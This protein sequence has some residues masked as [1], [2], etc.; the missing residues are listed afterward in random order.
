MDNK[1]VRKCACGKDFEVR[2][3]APKSTVCPEC[4]IA[5]MAAKRKKQ[6]PEP[7][8]APLPEAVSQ[9]NELDMD[10]FRIITAYDLFG[11]EAVYV[12][13]LLNGYKLSKRVLFKQ[14]GDIYVV[15]PLDKQVKFVVTLLERKDDSVAIET[16]EDVQ[17]LPENILTDLLPIASVVWPKGQGG[18]K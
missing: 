7:P 15:A 17:E 3:F 9:N 2:K 6:A 10:P 8:V 1:E 16:V 5:R 12:W 4:A 11:D 13:L 18:K 14:Y